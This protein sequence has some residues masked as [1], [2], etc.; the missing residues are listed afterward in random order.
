MEQIV[1]E[2]SGRLYQPF[3]SSTVAKAQREAKL[4]EAHGPTQGQTGCQ[5][6][7]PPCFK[8]L[9]LRRSLSQ[10]RAWSFLCETTGKGGSGTRC[11]SLAFRRWFPSISQ[12]ASGGRSFPMGAG[13]T[14]EALAPGIHLQKG[15]QVPLAVPLAALRWE[16]RTHTLLDTEAPQRVL[17]LVPLAK[18]ASQA[19]VSPAREAG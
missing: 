6:S 11:L 5:G 12:A 8:G 14:S 1:L 15:P 13:R 17:P 2:G 19:Y 18:I 9:S 16:P 3:L 10:K 4:C 7:R